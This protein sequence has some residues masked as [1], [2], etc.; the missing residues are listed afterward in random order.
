MLGWG[1][2]LVP[3]MSDG[4]NPNT[5]HR[6]K[7]SASPAAS[8]GRKTFALARRHDTDQRAHHAG[9]RRPVPQ[10]GGRLGAS[11][12]WTI[13]SQWG[14]APVPTL[15]CSRSAIGDELDKQLIGLTEM[16]PSD[17]KS[18]GRKMPS[19]ASREATHQDLVRMFVTDCSTDS[20]PVPAEIGSDSS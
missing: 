3:R 19:T 20:T 2:A 9:L 16:T 18:L 5:P 12:R 13:R 4:I 17:N 14:R 1:P 15:H 11:A 8:L 6:W 7:R 10:R